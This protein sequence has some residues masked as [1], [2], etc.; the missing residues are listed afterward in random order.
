ML[1][2]YRTKNGLTKRQINEKLQ[3]NYFHYR[4]VPFIIFRTPF[5]YSMAFLSTIKTKIGVFLFVCYLH[6]LLGQLPQNFF[7]KQ[8]Y[9]CV[10]KTWLREQIISIY[11]FE[12]YKINTSNVCKK[13]AY[14][15][16]LAKKLHPLRLLRQKNC[17]LL[18]CKFIRNC[19]MMCNLDGNAK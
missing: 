8:Q 10:V 9:L 17:T 7:K 18:G 13:I 14:P 1:K 16:A 3:V 15:Q 11:I 19:Y 2:F 6:I 5:C 12:F 4:A